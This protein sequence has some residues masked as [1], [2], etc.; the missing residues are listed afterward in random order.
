MIVLLKEMYFYLI[1]FCTLNFHKKNVENKTMNNNNSNNNNNNSDKDIVSRLN[2]SASHN[3]ITAI[4]SIP[5][6]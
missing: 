6:R 4:I 1:T 3:P 2:H 5:H